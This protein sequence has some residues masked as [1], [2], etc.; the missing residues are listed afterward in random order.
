MDSRQWTILSTGYGKL[1]ND[2]AEK[3]PEEQHSEN[4]TDSEATN[5]QAQP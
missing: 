5:N 3:Q 4:F 1:Q 2:Q